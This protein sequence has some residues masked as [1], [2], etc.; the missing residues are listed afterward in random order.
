[1]GVHRWQKITS[2][3][4]KKITSKS[5]KRSRSR[6]RKSKTEKSSKSQVK[7]KMSKLT[8]Y[9]MTA[10]GRMVEWSIW[11]TKVQNTYII[12]REHGQKGGKI[13]QDKGEVISNGKAGRTI[14]E[15]AT[16][17]YNSLLDKKLVKGYTQNSSGVNKDLPVSPMLAQTYEKHKSKIKFPALVQPKL[18]GVRCNARVVNG[19]V[20]LLSRRGKVF[21]QLN[22][23]NRAITS[24]NL[25]TNIV[26]DGEL[27]S[28]E[29][30]FQRVV[31]L[32]R[33]K[34]LST[35][36][37]K[38]MKKVKY[39]VFDL[40]DMNNLSMPFAER[41]KMAKKLVEKDKSKTLRLVSVYKVKNETDII[42]KLQ[43]FLANGDEGIMIRNSDSPY[44]IDKRSYNLQKYKKFLDSEYKIVGANQGKGNDKGTVVWICETDNG[45]RF[46]V[47]PKG[48][49][50]DRKDKYK[51]REKYYG[52]LLTVKYQELTN[53]SIPRFPVGIVIR[54]YE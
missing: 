7:S 50:A 46:K 23:I 4:Q 35:Q 11:M 14:L 41:W 39:D 18:D 24:I 19:K 43:E 38:D 31:G 8:L 28:D 53:D 48:T 32:V 10:G 52:K 20:T 54:D 33:K 51:N 42:E 22:Q 47:R 21:E 37:L 12:H 44:E 40:I 16:S 36:D 25:P 6:Q 45:K 30:D 13:V 15:Q 29:L 2:K 49:R 17:R 1:M 5:K 34:K 26:L 27:F 9:R 3:S